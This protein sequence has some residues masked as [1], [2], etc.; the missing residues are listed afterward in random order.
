MNNPKNIAT[1]RTALPAAWV[2]VITYAAAKF[3]F[4]LSDQDMTVLLLVIPVVLPIF[5][6][7][8]REIEVRYPTIGRIIFGSIKTPTYGDEPGTGV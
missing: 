8:A 5:Y 6:R 4:D 1:L 3:G 7:L 2:T